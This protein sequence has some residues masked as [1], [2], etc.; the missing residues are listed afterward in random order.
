[1]YN[2]LMISGVDGAGKTS[3]IRALFLEKESPYNVLKK[4]CS[5]RFRFMWIKSLHTLAYLIS[6]LV[7]SLS[8]SLEKAGSNLPLFPSW[9]RQ[10]GKPWILVELVSVLPWLT[11]LE[12]RRL[13]G[14]KVVVD[15][16]IADFLATVEV[17]SGQPIPWTGVKALS[18]HYIP[19]TLFIYLRIPP[20]KEDIV[21]VRKRVEYDID[22]LR[23]L[24]KAYDK[25]HA[26]LKSLGARVFWVDA[27]TQWDLVAGRTYAIVS[28]YFC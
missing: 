21:T 8:N 13:L 12:I 6:R 10:A 25:Y 26:I 24:I 22:T 2:T 20:G 14:Y 27:S 11:V 1:M 7:N 16:G 15:R 3:L 23:L 28:K 4:G 9:T 17:R 18:R 5:G 19:N